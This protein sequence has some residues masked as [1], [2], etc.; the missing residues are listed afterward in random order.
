MMVFIGGRSSL[1]RRG[2]HSLARRIR[3][4]LGGPIG[5]KLGGP[6]GWRLG[7][8]SGW[9]LGGCDGWRVWGLTG[10]RLAGCIGFKLGKYR[11]IL[12]WMLAGLRVVFKRL[13]YLPHRLVG[14]GADLAQNLYRRAHHF[15]HALG[16]QHD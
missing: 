9:R 11:R 10:R 12:R 14:R 6:S 15:G 8:P 7:G 2:G 13:G 1:A 16:T 3:G 4:R 5:W